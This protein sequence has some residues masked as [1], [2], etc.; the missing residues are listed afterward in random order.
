MLLHSVLN[1]VKCQHPIFALVQFPAALLPILLPVNEAGKAT[2]DDPSIRTLVSMCE[3]R[4]E[5]LVPDFNFAQSGL[6]QLFGH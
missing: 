3:P 5:I 6:F 2:E 4:L 1:Q